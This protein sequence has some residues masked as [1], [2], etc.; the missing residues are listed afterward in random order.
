MVLLKNSQQH[1]FARGQNLCCAMTIPLS[2]FVLLYNYW[3]LKV[4]NKDKNASS[5][6]CACQYPRIFE[7]HQGQ[8]QHDTELPFHLNLGARLT[9]L[10]ILSFLL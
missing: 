6:L 4:F 7:T 3:N 10:P 1:V 5:G 8:T 2:A 9:L